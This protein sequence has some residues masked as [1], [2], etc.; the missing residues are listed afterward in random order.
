MAGVACLLGKNEKKKKKKNGGG[1]RWQ[2]NGGIAQQRRG[3]WRREKMS[4]WRKLSELSGVAKMKNRNRRNDERNRQKGI[5]VMEKRRKRQENGAAGD[6]RKSSRR[7]S[8]SGENN[9]IRQLKIE[10]YRGNSLAA[11]T[12]ASES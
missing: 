6:N 10:P 1:Q 8:G 3:E 9:G 4:K 11:K 7:Q 12:M 2:N 5:S